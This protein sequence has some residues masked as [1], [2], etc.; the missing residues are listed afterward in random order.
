MFNLRSVYYYFLAVQI[1]LIKFFKKIYF[2]TDYYNKSL[3]SK[4]PQQFYFYPN[5]ILLCLI[6]NFK[7][8]SFKIKDFNPNIIWNNN[9]NL[10][11][12][13]NL[14]SFLWLNLI[15]R[16]ND[17]KSIQKIINLWMIKNSKYKK[18]I[19][20]NSVLSKRVISWILES[21]IIL[22]NSLFEFKR[23]FLNSIISQ[24]NHLKKNII[25]E[26]DNL[27]KIEIIVALLLS[28]LVFK[29]YNNNYK[30]AEKELEKFI[31][32]FFD[33]EG[34]PL[35]RN[36]SDLVFILKYLILCKE[37]IKDAQEYLPEF[38]EVIIN[39]SF[40][41][42]NSIL[43]PNHS[44]PLFNGGLEE[45]LE[46]LGK[47]ENKLDYKGKFDKNLIGGI[48]ILK[49]KNNLVFFDVGQPPNKQ[50]SSKYQSGPLSF[51]YYL[52]GKKIITN[53]GFGS[54]ISP[55]A[56]LFSRLTSAQ[57][58]VT[59]EDT[60]VTK[61]ERN[62]MINKIFG[63]SIKNSFKISETNFIDDKNHMKSIASHNGYEKKF[64]C[65]HKR[66]ISINKLDGHLLGNDTIIKKRDG[67]PINFNIR[68]HLTPDLNAV[69]TMGGNSILIQLSK[70]K[71][72][73]F[74]TDSENISLEKGVFFGGN[75]ILDNTCLT[76]SGNLVNKS[77]IIHWEIKKNI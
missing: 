58:T 28:G 52:D 38:L 57:S 61:F 48:Q 76:I 6:T 20:E 51:E 22:T 13:K 23:N 67:K 70:N 21:E 45:N 3:T 56:E 63:N 8:H 15:D 39:K 7:K 33:S 47:F 49:K 1:N 62:K 25:F 59:L 44:I 53:C 50:F 5:P 24:T 40:N 46:E 71:S 34:F 11:E 69:K 10:Q 68:F 36:P 18:N 41:C 17:G 72:L 32:D 77:K 55:K 54:N 2:T 73:I 37:C 27:K 9:K 64:G 31:K 16:K 14:H 30:L 43:T 66:E 65:T 12:E 74:I 60:S 26:K 29:E 35:S 19:W 42:L 4:T 75:K